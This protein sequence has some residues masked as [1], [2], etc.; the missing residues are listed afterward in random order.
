M[1]FILLF[2]LLKMS[3][4]EEEEKV[5]DSCTPVKNPSEPNDC[6]IFSKIESRCCFDKER[7]VC[8]KEPDNITENIFCE[9]DYFYSFTKE[10]YSTTSNQKGYCTFL[11]N[12]TKGSFSYSSTNSTKFIRNGL[13]LNCLNSSYILVNYF[14]ITTII[15]LLSL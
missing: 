5:A 12:Q 14:L 10:D 8:I 11:F 7:A 2:C 6:T 3:L 4:L 15:L 1:K 13:T 9:D